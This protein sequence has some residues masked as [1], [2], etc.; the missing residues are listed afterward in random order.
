MAKFPYTVEKEIKGTNYVFQCNGIAAWL[1]ALDECYVD[2]TS[3]ISAYKLNTYLLE[4][5][6]VNPKRSIDDFASADELAEVT[7]F[8]RK[9]AQGNEAPATVSADKK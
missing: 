5:V 4:N 3:N 8:A 7:A 9:V 2:G 1:K 6:V